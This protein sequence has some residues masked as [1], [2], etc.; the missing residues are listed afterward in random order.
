TPEELNIYGLADA[1]GKIII[2][3][4]YAD[5]FLMYVQLNT[6]EKL[7]EF[8]TWIRFKMDGTTFQVT[9][10]EIMHKANKIGGKLTVD[11]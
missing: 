1:S 3:M 2:P 5:I 4:E 10:E 9:A 6:E 8:E 11:E 7:R